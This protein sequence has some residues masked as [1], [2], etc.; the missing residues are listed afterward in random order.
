MLSAEP[1]SN[2]C[3]ACRDA[4]PSD[5]QYLTDQNIAEIGMS[6]LASSAAALAALSAHTCMRAGAAMTHIEK[7]R[8]QA[9]V[10]ALSGTHGFDLRSPA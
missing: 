8:L 7:M 5:M 6:L 2:C 3:G 1:K 9:A 10:Q 4:A